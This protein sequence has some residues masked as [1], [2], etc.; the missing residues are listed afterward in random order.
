MNPSYVLVWVEARNEPRA[1]EM[2][3]ALDEPLQADIVCPDCSEP[4]PSNFERCW[5]CGATI[6]LRRDER[7]PGRD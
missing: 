1:I 2:L 4:C 5:K 7:A 6:P 3:R